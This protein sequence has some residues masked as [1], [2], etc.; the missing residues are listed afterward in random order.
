MIK[1]GEKIVCVYCMLLLLNPG[2]RGEHPTD[3]LPGRATLPS[4]INVLYGISIAMAL[5]RVPNCTRSS[6]FSFFIFFNIWQYFQ[7]TALHLGVRTHQ[8]FLSFD[9]V[10]HALVY[11]IKT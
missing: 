8:P 6:L 1:A 4:V 5:A 2:V 7:Y 10:N 3:Q 11:F 9:F